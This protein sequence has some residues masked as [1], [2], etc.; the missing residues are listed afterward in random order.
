M[1]HEPELIAL[2]SPTP[3]LDEI[4]RA[5]G[6]L[7]ERRA[8]NQADIRRL[9]S[10]IESMGGQPALAKVVVEYGQTI[11]SMR[12]DIATV[13][14]F[15]RRLDERQSKIAAIARLAEFDLKAARLLEVSTRAGSLAMQAAEI[16][17]EWTTLFGEIN[18]FALRLMPANSPIQ[19]AEA[20]SRAARCRLPGASQIDQLREA[21]ALVDFVRGRLDLLRG[22]VSRS[23]EQQHQGKM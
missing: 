12:S 16:F 6:F 21:A 11:K 19:R 1:E 18:E 2:T 13:E 3:T 7:A 14:R 4:D 10:I 23:L 20:G 8:R 22:A 9:E 5:R 17:Q 15:Q